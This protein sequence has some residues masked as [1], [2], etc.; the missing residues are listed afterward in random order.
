[1]AGRGAAQGAPLSQRRGGLV[2]RRAP[3]DT[4]RHGHPG[5][6]RPRRG[7]RA[8]D[9][10]RHAPGAGGARGGRGGGRARRRAGQGGPA[11]GR[12]RDHAAASLAQR[13]RAP[14]A[15]EPRAGLRALRAADG[16]PQEGG[17]QAGPPRRPERPAQGR[18]RLRG[19]AVG[20]PR[21]PREV[22]KPSILESAASIIL[23]HNHPS[24]DPTPSREDLRL[25]RQLVE[26]SKLLDLR[27]HDH[28]IIGRERFISLAQRGAL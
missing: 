14:G 1:V 24:G 20:E 7:G 12:L 9:A 18:G 19:Y 26:C 27:I 28:V 4:A 6:E 16:R 25:T 13:Q 10:V 15:V 2:R 8:P 5:D 22:F 11:G 3:G 21:P 17:L 23:L